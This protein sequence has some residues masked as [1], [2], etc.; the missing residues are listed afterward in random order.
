[1]SPREVTILCG[2]NGQLSPVAQHEDLDWQP[3]KPYRLQLLNVHLN[4]AVAGNQH[5]WLF[6]ARKAGPNCRRQVITH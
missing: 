3:V 6:V 4:T 2:A 5:D 1:M